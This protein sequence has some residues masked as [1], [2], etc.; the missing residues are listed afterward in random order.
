M[1]SL[2]SSSLHV[3]FTIREWP[4]LFP[5]QNI[6]SAALFLAAKVEEQPQKLEYVAR[7]FYSCINRDH[8]NIDSS[9]EVS[10][11]PISEISSI[12]E[13]LLWCPESEACF[14]LQEYKKLIEEITAHELLILE[15]LGEF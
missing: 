2:D 11:Y 7:V 4:F 15:T 13:D 9:S 8:P 10:S 1:Y 12:I 14:L 5:P 3:K 6:A